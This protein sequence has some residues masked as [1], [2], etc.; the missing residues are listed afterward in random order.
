MF[1]LSKVPLDKAYLLLNHGPVT[2]VSSAHAGA[3]NI[4]A[5][6]W[7]MPLDFSPP[8]LCVV[9]DAR[10]RTRSL[11]EASGVFVLGIPT[12]AMAQTVLA[13]GSVSGHDCDKFSRFSLATYPAS[14]VEAP[15]LEGCIAALECKVIPEAHNQ[16]RYDLFIGEVA[17]AWADPRIFSEGRWHFPDAESHSLHY[18]AGG[19]FFATGES[20]ELTQ[21][22]SVSM[23]TDAA[24]IATVF[25][26]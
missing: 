6:A 8:K 10:S 20:V 26:D 21:G 7:A 24:A 16:Q 17:A 13:L 12:R 22:A 23:G 3:R 18:V 11:I 4:M 5:A 1:A 9:I 19:Q 2:L 25:P 14:Q 15:I